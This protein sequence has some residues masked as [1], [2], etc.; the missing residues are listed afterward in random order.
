MLTFC[1]AERS[2]RVLSQICQL[3]SIARWCKRGFC[4]FFSPQY[5]YHTCPPVIQVSFN[6]I[7]TQFNSA[8]T[9]CGG[10]NS[11]GF[12]QCW[13]QSQLF[14]EGYGQDKTVAYNRTTRGRFRGAVLPQISIGTAGGSW[15]RHTGRTSNLC[16][17]SNWQPS[18]SDKRERERER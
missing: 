7:R 11:A 10:W 1:T 15:R 4:F 5:Y 18:C 14:D 8:A 12:S 2:C 3:S 9:K 17:D 16:R 6:K 13:S